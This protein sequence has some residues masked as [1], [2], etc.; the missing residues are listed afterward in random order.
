LSKDYKTPSQPSAKSRLPA[1]AP[2]LHP[3]RRKWKVLAFLVAAGALNYADRTA[4]TSVFPLL[5]RDLAIS[6]VGLAAIGSLFLWSYAFA[7]PVAGIIADRVSRSRLIAISLV[8]WSLVTAATGL[9]T[10]SSQL[11]TIRVLL[12]LSECLYLPA[13]LGLLADYHGPNTRATAL[14]FHSGA[15]TMGMV[16]G[17]TVSGFLADRF[18]W[19]PCFLILGMVGVI[20][21]TVAAMWLRDAPVSLPDATAAE[22]LRT[23]LSAL[24][25]T[26]SYGIVLIEAGL[27]ALSTW[28]F[29]NWLPLYFRETYGITLAA[30]GF[31]GTFA[32]TAGATLGVLV[33]GYVSDRVARSGARRRLLMLSLLYTL[34]A[35]IL[36]VFLIHPAIGVLGFAI[37]AHGFVRSLGSVNELPLLCE[38]LPAHRRGTAFGLLNA[39]NT[40][41]GGSGVFLSGMLMGRFGLTQIFVGLAAVVLAA[42]IVA[43]I[44]YCWVLPADLSRRKLQ[45]SNGI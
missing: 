12:G 3:D 6:D 5:R 35:P 38:L 4:I 23:T 11:F 33:G 1:S 20:L 25:A 10:N 15:L 37:L 30:A 39:L 26:P 16:A 32:L 8:A 40:F 27:I 42:S 41:I 7:S 18:G 21:A 22:P 9:V 28:V 24:A 43:L 44:G 19:R 31:S 13:A 34:S 2:E 36:L 29:V 14:G 45:A 17:S